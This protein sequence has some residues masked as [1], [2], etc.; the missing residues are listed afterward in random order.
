MLPK[1]I[2][3]NAHL[4]GA[5]RWIEASTGIGPF[6]HGDIVGVYELTATT[7]K[8]CSE[9]L[10]TLPAKNRGQKVKVKT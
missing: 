9:T 1:I 2:Y 8:V 4:E 3:A 7:H 5:E 10:E 6:K